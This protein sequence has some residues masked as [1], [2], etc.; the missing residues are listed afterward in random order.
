MA[1]IPARKTYPQLTAAT[2]VQDADLLASYRSTGPLKKLTAN[3]LADYVVQDSESFLQADADAVARTPQDKLQETVSIADFGAVPGSSVNDALEKALATGKTVTIPL[4]PLDTPWIIDADIDLPYISKIVAEGRPNSLYNSDSDGE[5]AAYIKFSDPAYSFVGGDFSTR[6]FIYWSNLVF[7]GANGPRPEIADRVGSAI[8]GTLGGVTQGLIFQGFQIGWDNPFAYFLQCHDTEVLFCNRG[9][10]FDYW[11]SSVLANFFSND[12]P[13]P[14]DCGEQPALGSDIA[15][16][17]GINIQDGFERGLTL[18]GQV[19]VSGAVYFE[20]FPGRVPAVNSCLIR[21]LANS[22]ANLPAHIQNVSST[23]TTIDYGIVIDGVNNTFIQGLPVFERIDLPTDM[24]AVN[25]FDSSAI[26]VNTSPTPDTITITAHGYKDGARAVFTQGTA[27]ITGLADGAVVYIE[28]VDANTISLY[29]DA[30]LT[31][32]VDITVAGSG[33][34]NS[35]KAGGKWGFGVYPLGDG[36]PTYANATVRAV[37]ENSR[38]WTVDDLRVKGSPFLSAAVTPMSMST[39][40]TST[41][42]AGSTYVVLPCG[43]V[44]YDNAGRVSA[45]PAPAG[46]VRINKTGVYRITATFRHQNTSTSV[47]YLSAE[48][49]IRVNSSG[50]ETKM[51]SC[52]ANAA[53]ATNEVITLEY[54]N[55]ITSPATIDIAARNGDTVNAATLIIQYLGLGV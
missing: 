49:R 43:V 16:R 12:T 18:S 3:L 13:Y 27:P 52:P 51:K 11:N 4:V 9:L 35:L 38:R 5:V 53:G 8:T 32:P 30:A 40:T 22:D 33:T 42:V 10:K 29:T 34:G 6:K 24:G 46:S 48:F 28:V 41:S 39:L 7:I 1:L 50:V 15:G 21:Y 23:A 37:P 14:F 20:Q 31:T 36:S 54:L 55:T 47:N 17:I 45:S 25:S 2:D 44:V 26:T 19:S